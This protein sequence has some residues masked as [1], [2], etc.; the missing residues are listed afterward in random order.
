VSPSKIEKVVIPAAGLGTRLL[1][2][3]KETPKEML[4]IFVK[5]KRGNVVIKPMLQKI[6]E[7]LHDSGFREYCFI[8]GRGKRSI[9]DHFLVEKKILSELIRKKSDKVELLKDFFDKIEDSSIVIVNQ[10]EALGF[11]DAIYRTKKVVGSESFLLH[12]G[13]DLILSKN[14]DHIT[15]L[16]TAFDKYNCDVIFFVEE[17][18][19]PRQYGVIEGVE[20]EHNLYEV[21]SIIEKPEFPTSNLA[22]IAVYIFKPCIFDALEQ[23]KPDHKGEIQLADA[24]NILLKSGH[25][26]LAMELEKDERRIDIG[27]PLSYFNVLKEIYD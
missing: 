8:V 19:D 12:A 22:I 21:N 15:R 13:D 24:L 10:P 27:T 25:K 6:Y 17:I 11:G 4:P 7:T 18:D 26:L 23:V 1:P 5:D 2:L 20:I 3:T 14:N 9:E 16:M